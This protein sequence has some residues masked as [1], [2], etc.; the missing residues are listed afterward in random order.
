MTPLIVNAGGRP[1][2]AP[3]PNDKPRVTI[4]DKKGEGWHPS[5]VASLMRLQTAHN[6]WNRE[7]PSSP[8]NVSALVAA[9]KNITGC[10]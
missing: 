3:T 7:R 6:G 5:L 1:S 2:P 10:K 9:S 4:P 8:V